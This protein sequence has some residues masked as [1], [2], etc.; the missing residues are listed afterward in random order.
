MSL[1]T[2]EVHW[3][4]ERIPIPDF[5]EDQIHQPFDQTA[6]VLEARMQPVVNVPLPSWVVGDNSMGHCGH[7]DGTLILH[8]DEPERRVSVS[9]FQ[10][11]GKIQ[12]P[13]HD[14]SV[15]SVSG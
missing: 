9:V 12:C 10:H 11:L 7:V 6:A 14:A 2:E 8:F 4:G 15:C 5:S 13:F 1:T 3:I